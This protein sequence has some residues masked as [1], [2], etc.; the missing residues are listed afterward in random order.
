MVKNSD[1]NAQPSNSQTN[2]TT[3]LR[4]L[5]STTSIPSSDSESSDSDN[6][7]EK[8]RQK[9]EQKQRELSSNLLVKVNGTTITTGTVQGSS[10]P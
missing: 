8:F 10:T 6:E 9:V 3:S 5:P 2:Q 4:K 1:E 7:A